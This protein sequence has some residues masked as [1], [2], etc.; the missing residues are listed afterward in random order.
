MIWAVPI[1]ALSIAA[2]VGFVLGRGRRGVAIIACVGLLTLMLA[3]TLWT[4]LPSDHLDAVALVAA[5]ALVAMPGIAGVLG[6]ALM[7]WLVQ[8][9]SKT[10]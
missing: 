2:T 6:G 7:G 10:A 5:G 1:T 8:R 4:P 3:F 9:H